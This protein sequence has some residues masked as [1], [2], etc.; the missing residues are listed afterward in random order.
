MEIFSLLPPADL[1]TAVLVCKQWMVVGETPQLWSWVVVNVK[2][3]EDLLKL[4]KKRTQKLK[5]VKV[6]NWVE[7]SQ[8]SLIKSTAVNPKELFNALLPITT[9]TS[10]EG[11][12]VVSTNSDLGFIDL[13]EE[14]DA[15]DHPDLTSIEPELFARVLSRLTCLSFSESHPTPPQF[16]ALFSS[17]A[18]KDSHVKKLELGPLESFPQAD[19]FA[20]AVSNVE[21]CVGIHC[22]VPFQHWEALLVALAEDQG[23]QLK[24]LSLWSVMFGTIDPAILGTAIS[25]LEYATIHQGKCMLLMSKE[26]ISAILS[27]AGEDGS[28]LKKLEISGLNEEQKGEIDQD[29]LRQAGQRI[30][31]VQWRTVYLAEDSLTICARA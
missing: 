29:V 14:I 23:Q 19:V 27:K 31:D 13:D 6:T 16:E 1:K 3:K 8:S 21:E 20:A 26:Q 17:I 11:L 4:S 22:Y 24:K 15:P 9:L 5:K 2:T 12:K 10:I 28:K 30:G 25:R 18:E 7:E